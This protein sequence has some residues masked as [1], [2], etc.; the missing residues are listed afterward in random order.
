M[1]EDLTNILSNNSNEVDEQKLVEYL[2][3]KLSPEES[4]KIERLINE[5]GLLKDAVQGLQQFQN[6][7]HLPLFVDHLNRNLHTLLLTKKQRRHKRRFKNE[8]WIY[9][10]VIIVLSLII[11]GFMVIREYFIT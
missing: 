4:Q 6:K 5:P 2:N 11:L 8:Q 9:I 3:G 1:S 7:D 10:A